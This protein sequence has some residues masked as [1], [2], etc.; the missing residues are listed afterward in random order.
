MLFYIAGQLKYVTCMTHNW[1]ISSQCVKNYKKISFLYNI[2]LLLFSCKCICKLVSDLHKNQI[3]LNIQKC[4][5]CVY[6]AT[7][8]VK[9]EIFYASKMFVVLIS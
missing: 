9:S 7:L 4:N 2:R 6:E 5:F 1:S 3:S 8:V